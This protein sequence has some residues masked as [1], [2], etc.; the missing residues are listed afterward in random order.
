MHR[1]NYPS[2]S[3]GCSYSDHEQYF[4]SETFPIRNYSSTPYIYYTMNNIHKNGQGGSEEV[5]VFTLNSPFISGGSIVIFVNVLFYI[6]FL[7][8]LFIRSMCVVMRLKSQSEIFFF[9]C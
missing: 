1:I 5:E 9:S 6:C 4:N 8:I 7:D 3:A 2:L